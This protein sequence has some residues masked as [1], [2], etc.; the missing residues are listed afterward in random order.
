MR[1]ISLCFFYYKSRDIGVW[2]I[3][4]N[5]DF[6]P[7]IGEYWHFNYILKTYRFNEKNQSKQIPWFC[8]WD[9]LMKTK[10]YVVIQCWKV[11]F[12]DCPPTIKKI[13]LL[14]SLSLNYVW[15][16]QRDTNINLSKGCV[17]SKNWVYRA[18]YLE[19]VRYASEAG[20]D[21]ATHYSFKR[22][23]A[24]IGTGTFFPVCSVLWKGF[25]WQNQQ[26]IHTWLFSRVFTF[27]WT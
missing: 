7:N 26:L 13:F 2:C 25:V 12:K 4:V 27:P 16:S 8:S 24:K 1:F 20:G 6:F 15:K 22:K 23:C 10:P 17:L 9:C 3:G 19:R 18:A 21:F 5:I 11:L 14:K